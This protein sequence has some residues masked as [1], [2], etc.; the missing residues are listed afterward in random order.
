MT[1]DEYLEIEQQRGKFISGG[2]CVLVLVWT[3]LSLSHEHLSSPASASQLTSSEQLAIDAEQ[4]GTVF[5][6]EKEEEKRAKDEKWARYT[7][8]HPKGEGNTMNRG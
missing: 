2:G 1:V 7:D 6:R 8:T 4:D 3:F 5:G